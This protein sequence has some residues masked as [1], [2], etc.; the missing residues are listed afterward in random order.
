LR[1][2]T[3]SRHRATTKERRAA[4]ERDGLEL[5]IQF[6]Y[7]FPGHQ[8]QVE[9]RIPPRAHQQQQQSTGK[10]P[11]LHDPPH[12]DILLKDITDSGPMQFLLISAVC[13]CALV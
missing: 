13:F 4:R 6:Q 10:L 12:L 1:H 9:N 5:V 11:R 8:R 2:P 7:K 3:R